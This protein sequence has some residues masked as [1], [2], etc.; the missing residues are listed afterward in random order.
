M[1]KIFGSVALLA[2]MT[3]GSRA[4]PP[5]DYFDPDLTMYSCAD[6]WV[7][8]PLD[9]AVIPITTLTW[10]ASLPLTSISSSAQRSYDILVKDPAEYLVKR[11]LGSFFEWEN[12][13]QS[14]A[15]V[16]RFSD[17]Y[18]VAELSPSQE[19]RY[20]AVLQNHQQRLAAIQKEEGV[21]EEERARLLAGEEKRWED[22][23]RR[24]LSL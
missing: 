21:P 20:R 18:A 10:V 8:R 7:V 23:V 2:W 14:R 11:P 17:S 16:I 22:L 15:V 5:A 4:L 6:F 12:R 24:L 19:E 9:A 1:K 3:S 13:D